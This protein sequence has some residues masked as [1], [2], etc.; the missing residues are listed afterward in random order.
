[1]LKAGI[2]TLLVIGTQERDGSGLI[3]RG[4]S[5]MTPR[6]QAGPITMTIK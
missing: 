3:R 5:H 4:A 2:W 1:M 6:R